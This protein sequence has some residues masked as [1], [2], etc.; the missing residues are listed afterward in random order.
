MTPAED[1]SSKLIALRAWLL[2]SRLELERELDREPVPRTP[3]A[4]AIRHWKSMAIGQ[5][6]LLRQMT[7]SVLTTVEVAYDLS[8]DAGT[9]GRK[10][11]D[12][13]RGDS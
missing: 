9:R 1:V 2:E 4:E 5:L 6:E 13:A 8:L 11:D 7:S 12:Y 10:E 3:A